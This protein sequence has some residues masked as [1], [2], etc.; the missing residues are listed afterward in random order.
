[1]CVVSLMFTGLEP[2]ARSQGADVCVYLTWSPSPTPA[3]CQCGLSVKTTALIIDYL[4]S[5]LEYT[6]VL[7][8]PNPPMVCLLMSLD[9]LLTYCH[10]LAYLSDILPCASPLL[11]PPFQSFRGPVN[12]GLQFP[13]SNVFTLEQEWWAKRF[14]TQSLS[15]RAAL[16]RIIIYLSW[17]M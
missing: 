9:S 15:K 7:L 11:S 5:R 8:F 17:W 12:H 3:C 4:W 13:C 10:I 6:V 1:M 2:L 14:Q 16:T